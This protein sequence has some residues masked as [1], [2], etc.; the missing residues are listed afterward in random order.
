M[1]KNCLSM[2]K[3]EVVP[4]EGCT[5]PIAV[6]Y[7]TGYGANLLN[8][9]IVNIE[10]L[11]SG[12][13][14]KNAFGVGIPGT[15]KVGLEIAA[16]LGAVIKEPDKK[17]E[18][19]SNFTQSQLKEAE[20]MLDK[21]IIKTEQKFIDEKLYIE[22]RMKGHVHQVKVI[23]AKEH[24]NV[25]FVEVDNTILVDIK[26]EP[27]DVEDEQCVMNIKDIYEY[28]IT[29][30]FEEISF[31]LDSVAM[32]KRVSNE[33]LKGGYGLEVGYKINTGNAKN[34]LTDNVSNQIIAATAA[35]SDARMDGCTMPIM[36]TAGSGNQGIA[37]SIPVIE[38]AHIEGSSSEK[39]ARALVISNLIVCHIKEYMGRLSPLCGAG[40][41]GS[42]G[43]CCGLTYLLGGDLKQIGY[44]INNMM[45]DLAGLICDGA[46]TTCALKI[47][48]STNAA[49]QCCTLALNDICPT[50]KEGIIFE[51]AEQTIRHI[52]QLIRGGLK[53]MDSA[54]LNIMLNKH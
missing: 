7:A 25:V 42:T 37:C 39:L 35:A 10:L 6:A 31:I 21:H 5:E 41:A 15:G 43:A 32:N 19:L 46:K 34:I 14:I 29:A 49:I 8:E 45:A 12:N 23:I 36:T 40:M 44:A 51:D 11:L 13:I 3:K 48:T 4:A 47:A 2:L 33:G 52:G 30:P 9:E 50:S 20:N 26:M 28:A 24:T 22:V 53:D 1:N 16:A 38:L 17:L 27:S 54:I 18:I